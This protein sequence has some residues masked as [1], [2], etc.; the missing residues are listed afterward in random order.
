MHHAHARATQLV[1]ELTA[2]KDPRKRRAE[3]GVGAKKVS[4]GGGGPEKSGSANTAKTASMVASIFSPVGAAAERVRASAW[5]G[6]SDCHSMLVDPPGGT[7]NGSA[8]AV[9]SAYF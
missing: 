6:A 7:C 5:L 9:P 1:D 3:V 4:N 2:R 8:S